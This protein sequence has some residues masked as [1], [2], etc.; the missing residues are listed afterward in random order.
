MNDSWWTL[1]AVLIGAVASA[2]GTIAV[3]SW[4]SRREQKRDERNRLRADLY[5]LNSAITE[6]LEHF[7]D[8]ILN[9]PVEES[10]YRKN[11]VKT[12]V[13]IFHVNMMGIWV[14]DAPILRR[15]EAMT[16]GLTAITKSHQDQEAIAAY[17][18]VV[19]E[20][21]GVI[22]RRMKELLHQSVNPDRSELASANV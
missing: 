20:H 10:E 11:L 1:T 22:A 7:V 8:E 6:M 15:L 5:E 12:N 19:G 16:V 2:T 14:G 9:R 3:E 13:A 4:K 18:H 21:M 17:E